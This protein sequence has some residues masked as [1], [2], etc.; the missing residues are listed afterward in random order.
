MSCLHDADQGAGGMNLL[1][2]F[3]VGTLAPLR[4]QSQT[5]SSTQS[6]LLLDCG[7]RCAAVNGGLEM[8]ARSLDGTLLRATRGLSVLPGRLV[9]QQDI[10]KQL[11]GRAPV[12]EA[13]AREVASAALGSR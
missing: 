8:R 12:F 13:A 2:A 1:V 7:S 5:R 10:R 9:V 11:Y 3:E 4:I 6:H